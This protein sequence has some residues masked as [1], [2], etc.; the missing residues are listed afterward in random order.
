MARGDFSGF[1]KA[2]P[3]FF[4]QLEKNNTREW[5]E[6]HRQD[7]EELYVEPARAFV[8][9]I[10]PG[11]RKISASVC[12]EPR[13]NGS[14]MRINRDTRFS[15]D[16]KPY[17]NGLHFLFREGPKGVMGTPGF[18]I[19]IDAK[20]V[21]FAV[22]VLAM[23][24]EQLEHFRA[25]AVDKTSGAALQKVVEAVRK[26]GAAIEGEHFK[27][28][29]RGYDADHPNAALLKHI[30]LYATRGNKHPPDLFSPKAVDY[31]LRTFV[32]LYP[33]QKWVVENVGG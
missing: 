26:S 32:Q 22:G 11:L 1:P 23:V 5:F 29:P 9:A 18:Y 31:C 28:L 3:R 25:A 2:L 10:A 27:R 30:G 13:I 17:K 16:K 7:Y 20:E 24:P 8:T 19:R 33:V 21:R 15:T 6:S 4:A 14:I 12:A